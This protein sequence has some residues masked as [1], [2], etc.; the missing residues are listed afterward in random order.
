LLKHYNFPF[1]DIVPNL[2]IIDENKYEIALIRK[3]FC[4]KIEAD[5]FSTE[6]NINFASK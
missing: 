3:F 4:H 5:D 2:S 6:K 1:P